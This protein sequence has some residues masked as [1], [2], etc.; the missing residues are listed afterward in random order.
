MNT[1]V[2]P[3][4]LDPSIPDLNFANHEAS[5]GLTGAAGALAIEGI[6]GAEQF[7]HLLAGHPELTRG[8]EMTFVVAS[9]AV[10]ACTA[11]WSHGVNRARRAVTA[12]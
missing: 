12:R 3:G 9:A 8:D 6:A 11:I 10:L 4:L 2:E 5:W 7:Y 1:S